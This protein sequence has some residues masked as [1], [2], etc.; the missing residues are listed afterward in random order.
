M[1]SVDVKHH[2][3]LLME[4]A[5]YTGFVVVCFFLLLLLLLFLFGFAWEYIIFEVL[6]LRLLRLLNA[7]CAFLCTRGRHPHS[8][9]CGHC[10][11]RRKSKLQSHS[12][13]P[14]SAAVIPQLNRP[15]T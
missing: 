2:V 3:Y 11:Q 13:G 15:S 7:F 14:V 1:V 6:D 5:L 10:A 8:T 12:I 4:S 9:G